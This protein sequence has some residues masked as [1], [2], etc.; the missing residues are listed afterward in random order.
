MRTEVVR[1]SRTTRA[2][3]DAARARVNIWVKLGEH[4][5]GRGIAPQDSFSSENKCIYV[6]TGEH[7]R[8]KA[9][10]PATT[11]FGTEHLLM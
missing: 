11:A 1:K 10:T 3:K 6:A 5:G 8:I 9:G 2:A 4:A 7:M